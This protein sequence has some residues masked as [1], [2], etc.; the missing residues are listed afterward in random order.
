MHGRSA[1]MT[2]ADFVKKWGA[3]G[4][5][6]KLNERAGSQQHFLDL[7]R[8]LSVSEPDDPDSYCFERSFHQHNKSIGYA[9]VWKRNCFAWEYKRPGISLNEALD[10]L[11]RYALPLENPPLLV[12]SDREH[13]E[14]HTH[15]TGYASKRTEL[16]HNDLLQPE[17][18]ATLRA[19]FTAPYS[20]RPDRTSV[21]ITKEAAKGFAAIADRMEARGVA[22]QK[23][24]H[25]LT[26]CLFCLFAQDTNLLKTELFKSLIENKQDAVGLRRG[27]SKLFEVMRTGGDFGVENIPWF[28]GGLFEKVDVPELNSEDVQALRTAAKLDWRGLDPSIFGTLFERGLD[29]QKRRQLG[30]HYT[31]PET[32]SKLLIPVIERPLLTEWSNLKVQIFELLELARQLRAASK[33]IPSTSSAEQGRYAKARSKAKAA[34][35]RA[36]DLFN[37]Y[38]ERLRNFRVLDPACGS[39]N[40]LYLALR[41]LKDIEHHVNIEAE[42]LG[43]HRQLPL[44]GPQNLLGIEINPYAA[45][46]SRV[47]VWIGELQ[48]RLSHGFGWKLNP[49]LDP[50][51]QIEC[52]DA[53][54]DQDGNKSLWPKTDVIVGNPP[55]LGDRKMIREL[56]EPYVHRLRKTYSG[57]V[58]GGADLVCYWFENAR[59]A[60]Q[61]DRATSAGLVATNSIRGGRNRE[62]LE[63]IV[64][65]TCITE[66]WSDM[67]WVNNGAAVRV[68]LVVFG[69]LEGKPRLNGD[70]VDIIHADL[71]PK[72]GIIGTDVAVAVRLLECSKTCFIGTQKNGPF[73]IPGQLARQWLVSPNVSGESNAAVIR[74]WINGQDI[75]KRP[76]D[77]W[78]ID[79]NKQSAQH[80]AM[81]ELPFQYAAEHVQPTREG[82]RRDWHRMNWWCHGDPRPAMKAAVASL[83]RQIVS[84]RVSKHR[85]FVWQ[86]AVVLADSAVVVIARADDTT[87]GILHS[88]FHELWSLRTCTWMGK[89]N[90]PRYTPTTCFETF[91]FPENMSPSMTAH[92]RTESLPGGGLIPADLAEPARSR[93]VAIASAAK[94]LSDLRERWLNPPEWCERIPEVSPLGMMG[95]PYPDR[96]LAKQGFEKE[97][98]RRTLTNLY[99]LRPR[100][101]VDAHERL[102]IA[103]AAAYGWTDY[104]PQLT[105]D[106]ILR[107]L[108]ALNLERAALQSGKQGELPLLGLAVNG[109]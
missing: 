33:K 37:G 36:Q 41:S 48:W 35:H 68:S 74:P 76:S 66:A 53:I 32:I 92:Q 19:V 7:C 38:L 58:P 46:L 72:I 2:P 12:V 14:I 5:A 101:L 42:S 84:P 56:G 24:A 8:I 62:V 10:Q 73:D 4:T 16:E 80:A 27:L 13:F 1:S 40:F 28:N 86:P 50:L 94:D 11:M 88:R 90:D 64:E 63:S 69:A 3:K 78:I 25:F 55:F 107:R 45:E 65:S 85:V 71:T 102:D 52:R 96:L 61:S 22:P 30:A 83:K 79:F 89:G 26:Q 105:D 100:W 44:T 93:A 54:L 87:F 104:T 17:K 6:H 97:L 18:L 34:E 77:T 59:C 67:E 39:G 15:F 81:F 99:N 31:D 106:E 20:F 9:D 82:L 98:V 75:T 29:P 23:A 91:S 51:D 57:I 95:A 47:T 60:I 43:L 108:L 109:A 21:E 70:E 103:V 49:I